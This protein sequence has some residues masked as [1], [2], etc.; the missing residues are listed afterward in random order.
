MLSDDARR[1]L[2]AD[3]DALADQ[4]RGL[5]TSAED[6]LSQDASFVL[7][8]EALRLTILA[9][10]APSEPAIAEAG[11]MPPPT[12]ARV[13]LFGHSVRYGQV[14]EVERYGRRWLEIVE[15]EMWKDPENGPPSLPDVEE[16]RKLYHPNSVYALDEIGEDDVLRA[17]RNIKG[18]NV[19][20]PH[21][22]ERLLDEMDDE[23]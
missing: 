1:D 16:H 10:C 19:P 21:D 23:R 20:G 6:G 3:A 12:W 22:D 15:P 9:A 18:L 8:V 2:L 5:V 17:L 7:Q 11:P 4:S 14:I 13:E